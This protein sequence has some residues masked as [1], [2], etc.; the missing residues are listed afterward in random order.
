MPAHVLEEAPL[1]LTLSNNASDIW[2]E[3]TR[4]VCSEPLTGDAERLAR[5]SPNDSRNAAT[6]R[7]AVEGSQIRPYRRL[8]QPPR[9]HPR[10]QNFDCRCFVLHATD[11]PSSSDRQPHAEVE[12]PGS[13]AQTKNSL[14]TYIHIYCPPAQRS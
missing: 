4:V 14:G 8:I 7:S 13:G 10:S 12:S 11:G 6:P 1:G 5:I 2:P 9:F 3:V